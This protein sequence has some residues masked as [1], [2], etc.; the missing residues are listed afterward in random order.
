MAL[1]NFSIE[2]VLLYISIAP[3]VGTNGSNGS[4]S[5]TSWQGLLNVQTDLNS[6]FYGLNSSSRIRIEY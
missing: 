2:P 4:V 5:Y 1:L 3:E 6:G